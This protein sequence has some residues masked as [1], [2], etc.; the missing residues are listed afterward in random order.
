MSYKPFKINDRVMMIERGKLYKG[1][2]KSVYESL[3]TAVVMFDNGE[4]IKVS[5]NRL[6][7]DTETKE[8][9]TKE[10]LDELSKRLEETEVTITGKEFMKTVVETVKKMDMDDS[11]GE[12]VLLLFGAKLHKAIFDKVPE[13]D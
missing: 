10:S 3:N 2:I 9:E 1:T 8:S 7:H 6:A 13:N 4:Y 12:L 5:F 11:I